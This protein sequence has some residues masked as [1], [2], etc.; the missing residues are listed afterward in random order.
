MV[1]IS[2]QRH[3]LLASSLAFAVQQPNIVVALPEDYYSPPEEG[4]DAEHE[5]DAGSQLTGLAEPTGGLPVAEEEE[6]DGR[7]RRIPKAK[8]RAAVGGAR[9]TVAGLSGEMEEMRES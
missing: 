4:A 1:D 3:S 2:A 7:R 6:E 5:E 9:N 8:A